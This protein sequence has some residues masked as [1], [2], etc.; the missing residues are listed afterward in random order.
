MEILEWLKGNFAVPLTAALVFAAS[1]L[2]THFRLKYFGS[3]RSSTNWKKTLKMFGDTGL[4]KLGVKRVNDDTPD[5]EGDAASKYY[6]QFFAYHYEWS[7][8]VRFCFLRS[9]VIELDAF[10][11][12]ETLRGLGDN[13]MNQF[14]SQQPLP[15]LGLEEKTDSDGNK[16]WVKVPVADKLVEELSHKLI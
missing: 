15:C 2:W 3:R 11:Q 7:G 1:W 13:L 6:Q 12:W 8:G 10:Y 16:Y 14:A 4:F 5:S 9:Y